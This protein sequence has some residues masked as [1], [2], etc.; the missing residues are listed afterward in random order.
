MSG[1]RRHH[2]RERTGWLDGDADGDRRQP[3]RD[4]AGAHFRRLGEQATDSGEIA[5]A[6]AGA[7]RCRFE[8]YR[9]DEVST[10]STQFVGGD[11]HWRLCD[12]HGQALVDAGGYS[13][14]RTCRDAVAAL[15]EH[16]GDAGVAPVR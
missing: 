5:L 13:D 10:N 8:V 3:N 7:A 11:W 2:P 14:E 15:R 16:A 12:E 1:D 6:P 4:P 9:T